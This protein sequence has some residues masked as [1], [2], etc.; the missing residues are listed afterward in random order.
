MTACQQK[1]R[2]AVEKTTA[3]ERGR[4][5]EDSSRMCVVRDEWWKVRT[6]R[7]RFSRR[8]GHTPSPGT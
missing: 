7:R 3:R 4:E 5:R 6:N 2:L 1:E 8:G